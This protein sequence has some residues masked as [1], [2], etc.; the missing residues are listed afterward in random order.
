MNPGALILAGKLGFINPRIASE[1]R[2]HEG[3][4]AHEQQPVKE[5]E[6]SG[7]RGNSKETGNLIS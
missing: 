6:T 7:R 3:S 1:A 5:S 4:F 2:L